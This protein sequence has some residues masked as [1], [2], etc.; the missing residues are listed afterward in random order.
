MQR[1][2]VPTTVTFLV[3]IKLVAVV[4]ALPFTQFVPPVFAQH[5]EIFS[6]RPAHHV[7]RIGRLSTFIR[8]SDQHRMPVAQSV[9]VEIH[10]FV[11]NAFA[12]FFFNLIADSRASRCPDHAEQRRA[13]H[14]KRQQRSD[15][16]NC[17]T[18]AG[19]PSRS[20]ARSSH[21]PADSRTHRAA[22]PRL[23]GVAHR[24][25]RFESFR[26]VTRPYDAYPVLWYTETS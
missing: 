17:E 8:V 13:H 22:H 3:R 12:Q 2:S 11:R 19:Q 1:G 9:F 10:V 21:R 20:T 18:R 26:R 15:A 5:V 14:S 7:C 23:F 6:S 24:H 4:R 16:R 25:A